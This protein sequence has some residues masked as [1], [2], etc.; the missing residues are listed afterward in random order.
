MGFTWGMRFL[1]YRPPLPTTRAIQ[2]QTWCSDVEI[3]IPSSGFTTGRRCI[4]EDVLHSTMHR[5]KQRKGVQQIGTMGRRIRSH[6]TG[7]TEEDEEHGETSSHP[8][9]IMGDAPDGP[10]LWTYH[11]MQKVPFRNEEQAR[12]I[13]PVLR[14]PSCVEVE[15]PCRRIEEDLP[16]QEWVTPLSSHCHRKEEAGHSWA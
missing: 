6:R 10:R 8:G 12:T 3:L 9:R 14:I 2:A 5:S 11:A 7:R 1:P 16:R 4:D 15:S 13:R